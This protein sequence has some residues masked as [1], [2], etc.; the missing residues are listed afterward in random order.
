MTS[1]VVG[2]SVLWVQFYSLGKFLYSFLVFTTVIEAQALAVMS[3]CRRHGVRCCCRCCFGVETVAVGIGVAVE[4]NREE[5][6]GITVAVGISLKASVIQVFRYVLFQSIPS[7]FDILGRVVWERE[8]SHYYQI[9]YLQSAR[10]LV[11]LYM[12]KTQRIRNLVLP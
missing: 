12:E 10:T 8:P 2:L 9:V 6:V 3:L 7:Q 4:A 1:D 11:I 5:S